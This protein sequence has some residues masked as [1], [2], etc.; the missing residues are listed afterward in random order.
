MPTDK[1]K[2]AKGKKPAG[3]WDDPA[4][5]IAEAKVIVEKYGVEALTQNWLRANGH[6]SLSR[7]ISRHGGT[8]WVQTELG[9]EQGMKPSGYWNDPANVIAE[10][11]AIVEEHGPKALTSRWLSAN[12]PGSLS[13]AI[14][15]HGGYAWIRAELGLEQSQT[16]PRG[17]WSDPT[18]V[19]AEAKAVVEE[20]GPAA[21]T[22]T[23]L[24]ANGHNSLNIYISKNGGYVWIRTELSLEQGNKPHGYWDDRA[25]VIAEAKAIVETHGPEA[26]HKEWLNA[27]GH[28][29]LLN[30]FSKHGGIAWVRAELGL[31]Q[32]QKPKGYWADPANVIAEAKAIVEEHGP[33]ALTSGWLNANG[34]HSLN[35]YIA[36]HGGIAWI[37][38]ELGLEQGFKPAGYW[39]N[40][41][42]VIAEAKAIVEEHGPEAL[43][44]RWLRANG[45]NNLAIAIA[46]HGDGI[47]WVRAELGLE[48]VQKPMGYWADSAN[49]ISEARAILEMYGPDA[50]T[51]AWLI[52]NGHSGLSTAIGKQGGFYWIW[53]EL[54]IEAPAKPSG[55]D[56]V[57][58]A[59]DCTGNF[60]RPR[61]CVLYVI[62]MKNHPGYCKVGIS[63]NY[64]NRA[65][66]EY[67]KEEDAQLLQ[68]FS[69]R[70]E[71]YLIEQ[72]TADATRC[73]AEIP[74]GLETWGGA[75]EI[76]RM[77]VEDLEAV[78]LAMIQEAEECGLWEMSSLRVPMTMAQRAICQQRALAGAPACAP[79][80]AAA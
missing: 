6:S 50:L 58:K 14:V 31:D 10:A 28:G 38:T 63:F 73:F 18:N 5:V 46:R 43:N 9:L 17:Y 19:I 68:P 60:I 12:G 40:P 67:V 30:A 59:L 4:N 75:G 51:A 15:R 37:R 24:S 61:D 69:T 48:Q 79:A 45:H 72:A 80:S 55:G 52:A 76:R 62:E 7:A 71:P 74:E 47:A 54:G 42:N 32:V 33:K 77:P 36:R 1:N 26:L 13:S 64:K 70:Q 53:A 65:D 49:V 27:N 44:D 16:K 2:P 20:Y 57:Q 22:S 25:N 78:A 11:K 3:Y 35:I 39:H 66:A 34:H 56:S 8:A 29:G 41:A 23:W 21:L